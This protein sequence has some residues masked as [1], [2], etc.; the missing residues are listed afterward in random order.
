MIPSS[1]FSFHRNGKV[2]MILM[3]SKRSN[4]A[5]VSRKLVSHESWLE[6]VK[7]LEIVDHGFGSK[8]TMIG[9]NILEPVLSCSD[10]QIIKIISSF[11]SSFP[12]KILPK[13]TCKRRDRCF[14]SIGRMMYTC[15]V[16][17]N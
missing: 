7:D 14:S 3:G 4:I 5:N 16:H 1:S 10:I 8:S 2:T 9:L 11:I 17:V 12:M 13:Q 15:K 6:N